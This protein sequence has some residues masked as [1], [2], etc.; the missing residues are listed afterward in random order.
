M[1]KKKEILAFLPKI[2]GKEQKIIKEKS[3]RKIM[4][5]FGDAIDEKYKDYLRSLITETTV[6]DNRKKTETLSYSF[7][8][9]AFIGKGYNYKLFEVIPKRNDDPYPVEINLFERH[10]SKEG[11]F[12]NERT[13]YNKLSA[14]FQSVFFSNVVS[15]LSGQVDLYRE[16]RN[17]DITKK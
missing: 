6:L 12:Q 17:E 16:S 2:G 13:F 8:L 4:Q 1:T 3:P 15:N 11:I 14:F 10:P 9:V 7:Y 5:E